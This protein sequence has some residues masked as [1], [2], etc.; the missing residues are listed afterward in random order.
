MFGM[1]PAPLAIFFQFQFF[2][3]VFFVFVGGIIFSVA[4]FT[5]QRN[6]FSHFFLSKIVKPMPTSRNYPP[7]QNYLEKERIVFG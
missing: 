4:L 2:G 1:G 3:C 6:N 7:S 5:C